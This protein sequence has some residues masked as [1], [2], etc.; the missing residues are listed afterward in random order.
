MVFQKV[1]N[2]P[3]R[4]VSGVIYL[5]PKDQPEGPDYYEEWIW[6]LGPDE[7]TYVWESIGRTDAISIIV[8]SVLD[9][10]S[11]NPVQNKVITRALNNK[12]ST[13]D[14][15]NTLDVVSAGKV[16][17]ARQGKVLKDSIDTIIQEVSG[18]ATQLESYNKGEGV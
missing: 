1:D 4:G 14:V 16:L 9:L 2:L 12:V 13:T 15:T 6:C 11:E 3:E 10:T 18:L 7:L 8:D 17:D 5:V